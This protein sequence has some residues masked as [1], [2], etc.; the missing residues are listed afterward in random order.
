MLV[1]ASFDCLL[2][3]D[4]MLTPWPRVYVLDQVVLLEILVLKHVQVLFQYFIF[5]DKLLS[6]LKQYQENLKLSWCKIMIYIAFSFTPYFS[7][8]IIKFK[9][10][11]NQTQE[12]DFHQENPNLT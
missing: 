5:Q 8:L 3:L 2:L 7:D 12:E 10:D 11:R 4:K 1:S 9:H 6:D